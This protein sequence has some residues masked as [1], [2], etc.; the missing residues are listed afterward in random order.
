[1][2]S[3]QEAMPVNQDLKQRKTNRL[4]NISGRNSSPNSVRT[5][6]IA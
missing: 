1:M 5:S 2:G 3:C 6:D 4:N